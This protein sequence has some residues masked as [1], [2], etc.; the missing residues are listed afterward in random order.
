MLGDWAF[1][2]QKLSVTMTPPDGAA[3]VKRTGH[4]LTIF[5]KQHGKWLIARDANML[6]PA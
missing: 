3:S 6:A 2:W 4:T 5:T 1:M